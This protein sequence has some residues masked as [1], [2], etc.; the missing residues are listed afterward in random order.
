MQRRQFL[1]LF[2]P[3]LGPP[4]PNIVL[5]LADDLGWSDL[6]CYGADLHET[7]RL[8]RLARQSLRF[9]HA[10]SAAPVCSPTRASLLTGKHPARL[11]ITIWHEGAVDPPTNRPLLPAPTQPNHPKNPLPSSKL[12][13]HLPLFSFPSRFSVHQKLTEPITLWNPRPSIPQN[14]APPG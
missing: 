4:P 9:T 12:L 10:L 11:G 1:A 13:A 5:I 6:G 3:P 7:P 2:A 8:D 14:P